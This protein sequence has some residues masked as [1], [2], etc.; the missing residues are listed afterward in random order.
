MDRFLANIAKRNLAT[1]HPE[2]QR[3]FVQATGFSLKVETVAA[4]KTAEVFETR[5]LKN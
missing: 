1:V 3:Q 5:K 2:L 4:E